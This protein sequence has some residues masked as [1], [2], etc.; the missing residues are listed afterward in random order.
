MYILPEHYP[1]LKDRVVCS[2][3]NHPIGFQAC[4]SCNL[5]HMILR[6]S[7][8][9]AFPIVAALHPSCWWY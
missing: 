8:I 3:P 5:L 1:S 4:A 6:V 7:R 2:A 9:D